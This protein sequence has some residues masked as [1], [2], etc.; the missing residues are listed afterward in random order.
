MS[1]L[2]EETPKLAAAAAI[3]STAKKVAEK[4][5]AKETSAKLEIT[6]IK[7]ETSASAASKAAA[8]TISTKKAL[9]ASRLA[10]AAAKKSRQNV[11]SKRFQWGNL[12]SEKYLVYPLAIQFAESC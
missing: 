6:A 1:F 11:P 10:T 12:Y 9:T 4:L 5:T 2:L 7:R 8:S 3:Q